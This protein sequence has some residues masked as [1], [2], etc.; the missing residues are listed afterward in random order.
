MTLK[1]FFLCFCTSVVQ[2]TFKKKI[3]VLVS[4][5]LI[6]TGVWWDFVFK[7][8]SSDINTQQIIQETKYL[9][10]KC[11]ATSNI[12][13]SKKWMKKCFIIFTFS[14]FYFS[15]IQY[16]F[17][18]RMSLW[19]QIEPHLVSCWASM[20]TQS[21]EVSLN[22]SVNS[23]HGFQL[24]SMAPKR[25]SMAPRTTKASGRVLFAIK[26]APWPK[27]NLQYKPAGGGVI[28]GFMQ[29]HH[30]FRVRLQDFRVSGWAMALGWA[31][32]DPGWVDQDENFGSIEVTK[33]EC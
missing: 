5:A 33:T 16:N 13:N 2:V 29:S 26:R 19:Q 30:D 31:S 22:S 9:C 12:H 6:C 27:G 8:P 24:S 11:I 17:C 21:S 28:C 4:F 1:H 32:I 7:Y 25:G 10:S 23:F 15:Y 3:N 18:S 20:A 14:R